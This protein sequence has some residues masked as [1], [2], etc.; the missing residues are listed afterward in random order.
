[1]HFNEIDLMEKI[2]KFNF[3]EQMKFISKPFN[4]V[5]FI[6]MIIILY[7]Y[8]VLALDDVILVI[9]GTIACS[10]IK[11][12]YKRTRPYIASNKIKNYSGKDHKLLADRYS[13][14]SGHTFAA[15]FLSLVM[16][17][18]YPSEFIFNIVA[19]LVGFSRIFL[20]VHYPT[21]IIGGMLFGFVF[22]QILN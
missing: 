13:F 12:I 21:D 7:I 9:K 8:K 14:P 18:K 17:N 22:Y 4:T 11:Y 1:M 16:L 10:L 3:A 6:I 19:I 20:G 2:Q 5:F 15:T